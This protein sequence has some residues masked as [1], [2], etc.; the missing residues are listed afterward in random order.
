MGYKAEE[1]LDALHQIREENYEAT[2]DM[3]P[4]EWAEAANKRLKKYAEEYG[5]TIR[6]PRPTIKK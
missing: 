3:T 1:M 6:T 2:K 5:L 4:E